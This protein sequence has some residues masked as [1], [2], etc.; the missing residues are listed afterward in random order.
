[1]TV[2]I[3]N[4]VTPEG[5]RGCACKTRAR[6]VKFCYEYVAA[7]IMNAKA[8]NDQKAVDELMNF[9]TRM[10]EAFNRG[11]N[12]FDSFHINSCEIIE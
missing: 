3:V 9:G 12:S 7:T 2:Y 11:E 5:I 4:V 1:M 6:V 10:G 8:H